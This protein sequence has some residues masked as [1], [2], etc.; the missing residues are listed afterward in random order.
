MLASSVHVVDPTLR[1]PDLGIGSLSVVGVVMGAVNE[2][3]D[4]V[5]LVE[6]HSLLA[7]V[8]RVDVGIAE[9]LMTKVTEVLC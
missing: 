7:L 9:V 8:G 5:A 6:V 2:W 3:R 1:V 4:K